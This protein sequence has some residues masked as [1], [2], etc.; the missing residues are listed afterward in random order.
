MDRMQFAI[1]NYS[2]KVV[3]D[4]IDMV[5]AN[6]DIDN[7]PRIPIK[8]YHSDLGWFIEC[9]NKDDEPRLDR[10]LKFIFGIED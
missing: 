9:L 2:Y 5:N 3:S 4:T 6:C 10:H 1:G 8:F 7:E